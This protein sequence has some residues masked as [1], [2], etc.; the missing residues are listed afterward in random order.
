MNKLLL[1][2]KEIAAITGSDLPIDVQKTL[3]AIRQHEMDEQR[4]MYEDSLYAFLQAGWKY[5]DPN[6]F[7]D[8]WHLQAIAEHLEAVCDGQIKRLIINQPPRTSKSS[9]MVA[10]DAWCWAQRQISDTSG[11]GVQFLHS[12][13]AQTLSIRDS[14][15]T[16]RL[17]GSPWYQSLWGERFT[18]MGDQN[19]KTRFDNDK[20]GYRLATSVGGA[21]TGEGGGCF[22]AGTKVSTPY[23]DVNIEDIVVGQKVFAFDHSREKVVIS[24]ILATKPR[25]S[26]E[27]YEVHTSK[28]DS[29]ICTPDHPIFVPGRG[30]V[31]ADELGVGDG[32]LREKRSQN[33]DRS[34]VRLLPEACRKT[35]I[36]IAE[37]ITAKLKGCVLLQEMLL[38]ASR[39]K[40]YAF[41]CRVLKACA[42][43]TFQLLFG[44]LQISC[45]GQTAQAKDMPG[46]WQIISRQWRMLLADMLGTYSFPAYAGGQQFQ[47]QTAGQILE[48]VQTNGGDYQ[49]AGW[50]PLRCVRPS[51]LS[52]GQGETNEI[53]SSRSS[54]QREHAGQSTREP[55]HALHILPQ[56]PSSWEFDAISS[57]TVHRG[58]SQQVY[59]IQVERQCNF[60]ANGI[61]VHNCIIIDDPHNSVDMESEVI[62]QSTVEWFDNS[63]ST[64]LNNART[65]AIILVMQRLHEDDLTGHILASGDDSWVHLMLPMRYEVDRARIIYPNVIGWSDPRTE[66]GELLVPERYDQM[67]VERLERQ[68]GPFGS[69]GQL[70]QRPE[71]KGGGIIKR[72]WWMEYTAEKFPPMEYI[73]ASLDCAY[74]EKQENDYSALTVWG[75]WHDTGETTGQVTPAGMAGQSSFIR[76]TRVENE[77]IPRVMLMHAWKD[78]LALHDLVQRVADSC[79]RMKVDLLLVENKASGISVSQEIRRLYGHEDFG[80]Q[81]VDPK[82]Q[83]K[84]ARAYSIQHLFAEGIIYAPINF[85]WADMVVTE[86]SQ[87]PKGKHDDLVD[88]T[89]QAL[90][91]LRVTGMIQRGE[92]RT[93]EINQRKQFTG[94]YADTPLYP[95]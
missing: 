85:S 72:D 68:L 27:L 86:C 74:T 48:P 8:G 65:G 42:A 77:D 12:S 82:G 63:L 17:I 61:L 73:V 88:T 19:A 1:S 4:Q 44:N 81:L 83:D 75:V 35:I 56:E 94:N 25:E 78:H 62:R 14:V 52:G 43:Q 33:N 58:E 30:Y 28:G 87:F 34:S 29:F 7:V 70:Q 23:G 6:P 71:P 51:G 18:L 36:R 3:E 37:G 76:A 95:V 64:R 15:K 16:R 49:G 89:T 45:N 46:M 26:T 10:F 92:E 41:V 11:P 59:D 66:E 50:T 55:N 93:A 38:C 84:V 31:R 22:V 13:Y 54:Y 40:E 21:L 24:R 39:N 79:R 53:G 5:I 32:V 20:G 57:I 9:M 47:L 69:A 91:H 2:G 90:R 67:S 60:Y 80:V